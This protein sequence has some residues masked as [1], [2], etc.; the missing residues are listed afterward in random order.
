MKALTS[1]IFIAISIGLFFWYMEPAWANITSLQGQISQYQ[2]DL[3]QAGQAKVKSNQ[4]VSAYDSITPG[5]Q[6][7]LTTFLP[8]SITPV[9]FALSLNTIASLYSSGLESIDIGKSS[10]VSGQNIN[11]LPVTFSVAMTY[12]NFLL[13]L[14]KME[15]SLPPTDIT[16]L[17]FKTSDTSAVYT[18][19]VSVQ[20]YYL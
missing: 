11:I 15:Q 18:F 6:K 9:S 12:Q 8:T 3:D 17:S 19:N 14:K 13:F 7:E 4:L 5:Q 16:S 20:T 1:I 2:S 10:T